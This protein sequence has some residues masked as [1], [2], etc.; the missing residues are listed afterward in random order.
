[1]T[2]VG[3]YQYMSASETEPQT[4][5]EWSL[6]KNLEDA[7]IL[8]QELKARQADD[9]EKIRQLETNLKHKDLEYNLASR[10]SLSA[11]ETVKRLQD[12]LKDFTHKNKLYVIESEEFI[13]QIDM[14]DAETRE[15]EDELVLARAEFDRKVNLLEES[16]IYRRETIEERKITE[17]KHEHQIEIQ[18]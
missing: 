2:G 12:Q 16:L 18:D 15:K 9:K 6:K 10:E 8:I 7:E 14:A 3:K 5:K 13:K 4:L 1:M 11:Q 17:L